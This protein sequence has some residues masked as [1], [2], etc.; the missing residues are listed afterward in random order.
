MIDWH[1]A[2]LIAIGMA[3]AFG[4]VWLKGCR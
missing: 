4:L 2:E 1:S 3:I